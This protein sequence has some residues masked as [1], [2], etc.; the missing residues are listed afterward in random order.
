MPKLVV[1]TLIVVGAALL[2]A[3]VAFRPEWLEQAWLWAVGLFGLLYGGV[4]SVF[5][6]L[7]TSPEL[8]EVERQNDSL[9]QA[10]E[11]LKKRLQ[12]VD[13]ALADERDRHSR[14]M[15]ALKERLSHQ[16]ADYRRKVEELKRIQAMRYDEYFDSLS[17]EEQRDLTEKMWQRVVFSP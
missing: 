15:S 4:R 7:T 11:Q 14:Q 8:D 16:K 10:N 6:F 1:V 2:A 12:A 3:V 9:R 13:R 5:R 17:P